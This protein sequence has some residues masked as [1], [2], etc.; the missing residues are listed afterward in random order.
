[1]RLRSCTRSDLEAVVALFTDSVHGLAAG[2]YDPAQLAAWAPQPP[3]L[4]DWESRLTSLYTIVAE[5]RGE[6][7]GFVSYELDG[8][9][10]LLYVSPRHARRGVASALCD[11]A[12][13]ALAQ[14]GV[15]YVFTEAS[16]AARRFFENRGFVVQ[17]VQ[18]VR[19]RGVALK[20]YVMRK[21]SCHVRHPAIPDGRP[22]VPQ[23]PDGP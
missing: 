21:A 1:M 5:D 19:Q 4:S 12:E 20:R 10:D 9:L 13:A 11:R 14:A 7:L 2:D 15:R 3:D 22:A 6:L 8:H 16:L 23:V 17:G 18:I